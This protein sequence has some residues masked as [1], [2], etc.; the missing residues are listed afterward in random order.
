MDAVGKLDAVG[1]LAVLDRGDLTSVAL[2]QHLLE[3]C[4]ENARLGAFYYLDPQEV[5]KR[6]AEA[7]GLRQR[8]GKGEL[9]GL[10]LAIKDNINSAGIPTTAGTPLLDGFVPTANAAVLQ[11]LLDAGAI[12]LGKTAM[13]ELAFGITGNNKYRGPTRNPHD[14][15]RIPGGSSSGTAVAVAAGMAPAGL[16]SDTGGSLRIPAAL[17]GITA[18][19]PTTGRYPGR[20]VVPITS[21]RDTVG[22]M[23]RTVADLAL[24]DE[25]I[26]GSKAA[27]M[28]A[29][30]DIRFG[31]PDNFFFD[32]IDPEVARLFDAALDRLRETGVTVVP[33]NI[34]EMA[35]LYA[36]TGFPITLYETIPTLEAYLGEHG[37]D[38]S[39]ADI[40][41]SA[42]SDDVAQILRDICIGAVPIETYERA[43]ARDRPALQ[44]IYGDLF[45]GHRLDGILFPATPW[46]AVPI[47]IDTIEKEGR[48]I[49]VFEIFIRNSGPGSVSGVPGLSLPC[50]RTSG[51][52]PVGLSIDG[53]AFSDRHLLAVGAA[54]SPVVAA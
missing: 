17:C 52:L 20:G 45:A 15:D 51:G 16:G 46:P 28:V 6:A 41:A 13:H 19:R 53:A 1:L 32:D 10:P 4:E 22:P 40:A 37:L 42:A 12:L 35:Q 8:G 18:L 21:T 38:M 31:I 27:P 30:E 47:G 3:T 36:A 9:L 5:M 14:P 54:I 7:D 50:G 2:C 48:S 23:A 34:G 39:F 26:T 49:S 44:S 24:L 25:V 11:R 33:V 43:I 29:I